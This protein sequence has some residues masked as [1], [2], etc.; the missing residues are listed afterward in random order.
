MTEYDGLH[1]EERRTG[2][3]DEHARWRARGRAFW[4]W[5]ASRPAESWLFFVSGILLG[6]ILL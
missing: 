6:K 4:R 2:R 5:L 3:E 1:D